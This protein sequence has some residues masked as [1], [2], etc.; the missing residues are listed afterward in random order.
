MKGGHRGDFSGRR[1]K[2]KT[3]TDGADCCST[4]KLKSETSAERESGRARQLRL[5]GERERE[6]QTDRHTHTHTHTQTDR[7]HGHTLCLS[8]LLKTVYLRRISDFVCV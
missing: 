2:V 4:H 7:Q 8:I 5:E 6:R 1:R 3:G